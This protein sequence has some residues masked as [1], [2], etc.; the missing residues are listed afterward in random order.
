MATATA[1]GEPTY[2]L[3]VCLCH[4]HVP[5]PKSLL[6]CEARGLRLRQNVIH[7]KY[8]KKKGKREEKVRKGKRELRK[9]AAA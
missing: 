3:A 1:I 2:Y 8:T 6:S 4:R 9:N 7:R 5:R